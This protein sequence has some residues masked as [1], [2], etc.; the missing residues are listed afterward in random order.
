MVKPKVAFANLVPQGKSQFSIGGRQLDVADYAPRLF[1]AM[2]GNV[3][4]RFEEAAEGIRFQLGQSDRFREGIVRS[5]A[6]RDHI[7][8]TF[9]KM[10][11]PTELAALPHDLESRAQPG[12]HVE[13]NVWRAVRYGM[14]GRFVKFSGQ[15]D[16]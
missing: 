2:Y 14:D 1:E 6:W 16:F 12:R 5:G 10:G 11:L 4:S 9:K 13:E 8:A 15:F 3:R 7:A